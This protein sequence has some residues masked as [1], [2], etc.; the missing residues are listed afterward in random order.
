MKATVLYW[1]H[2]SNTRCFTVLAA[3]LLACSAIGSVCH[4]TSSGVWSDPLIWDCG[5][6]PADCDTLYIG[7]EVTV[8]ADLVVWQPLLVVETSGSLHVA[9]RLT[10]LDEFRNEG[11]L[12]AAE[13][14]QASISPRWENTGYM[15]SGLVQFMGDSA[16]N[17]GVLVA[18]DTLRTSDGSNV[19]N[20]GRATGGFLWPGDLYNFDTLIFDAGQVGMFFVNVGYCEIQGLMIVLGLMAN[21]YDA[22]LISDSILCYGNLFNDSFLRAT[23]LLQF[24]TAQFPGGELDVF[25]STARIECGNLKN[26]AHIQGFGDIC[27]QDSSIN[28]ATG[29]I[30]QSP[31]ICDA[32][33]TT[34]VDPFLDVNLGFVGAAVRWCPQTTCTTG[35]GLR[36]EFI[37]MSLYPVP[38]SDAVYI[39][40]PATLQA[41][42]LK[43]F[44]MNGRESKSMDLSGERS[45][46]LDRGSL[47]PGLYQIRLYNYEGRLL[48]TERIVFLTD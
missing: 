47:R 24:G 33:L 14:V 48:G 30:D 36:E 41:M 15:E 16:L 29:V 9:G 43:V 42:T 31:D 44:D 13:A 34:T 11:T 6:D 10:V 26:H 27:V 32:T 40:L 17:Y 19:L 21:D 4:T 25:P 12:Y 37:S 23:S 8:A 35:V 39:Q 22:Y 18:N 2:H 3:L 7:H 1:T 38:A 46:R 45:I 20:F 28:Y 5:C